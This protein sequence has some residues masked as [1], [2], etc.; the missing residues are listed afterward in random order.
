MKDVMK[1]Q[2]DN[3]SYLNGTERKKSLKKILA[4]KQKY[5]KNKK[6]KNGALFCRC[7][8]HCGRSFGCMTVPLGRSCLTFSRQFLNGGTSTANS[9]YHSFKLKI[10]TKKK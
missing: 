8:R 1:K 9:Q 10:G 2:H 4:N 5:K 3:D 7:R 6:K